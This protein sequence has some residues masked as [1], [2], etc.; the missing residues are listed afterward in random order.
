[1][2]LRPPPAQAGATGHRGPRQGTDAMS[3][4]GTTF[5]SGRWR[6]AACGA[7]LQARLSLLQRS[8]HSTSARCGLR[9]PRAYGRAQGRPPR[10]RGV[11]CCA[12]GARFGGYDR[13]RPRASPTPS[14]TANAQPDLSR[15]SISPP[16]RDGAREC[17]IRRLPLAPA[18]PAS[19]RAPCQYQRGSRRNIAAHYDLGND[20]YPHWLDPG[21]IYSSA[22]LRARR[23]DA[24]GGAG[25]K[26]GAHRR[27]A[28]PQPAT[29]SS[30]SAAAGARSPNG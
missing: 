1:M 21:M 13:R 6:L 4:P 28:R 23:A 18:R 2:P 5:R 27:A 25:R 16:Q 22:L 20:F 9:C 8:L 26:A 14:W 24:G 15:S 12:A 19:P 17:D 29:A 10:S 11:L 3:S 30:R 7:R